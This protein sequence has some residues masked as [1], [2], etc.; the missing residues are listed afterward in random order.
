M[1]NYVHNVCKSMRCIYSR[2]QLVGLPDEADAFRDQ[3]LHLPPQPGHQQH[4]V[5]P[6]L[7]LFEAPL[8]SADALDEGDGERVELVGLVEIQ[9]EKVVK[10]G[11]EIV[12]DGRMVE[13][14]EWT[15]PGAPC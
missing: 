15:L 5:R 7:H 8:V 13:S 11:G 14:P 4:H 10:S 12:G 6:R 9:G 3:V 1:A 2:V